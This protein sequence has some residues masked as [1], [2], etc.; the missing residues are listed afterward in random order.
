MDGRQPSPVRC[1]A[2]KDACEAA[3]NAVPPGPDPFKAQLA[4]LGARRRE[5]RQCTTARAEREATALH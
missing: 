2:L 4:P 3:P 1:T 5:R